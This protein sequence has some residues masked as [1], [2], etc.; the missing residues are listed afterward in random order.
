M[1]RIKHINADSCFL[2]TFLPSSA[3]PSASHTHPGAFTILIDPWLSGP[4]K[5]FSSSFALTLHTVDACVASLRDLP[6]PDLI[7]IS[8]D[9]NDHC[10]KATLTELPGDIESRIV[11]TEKAVRKIRAWKHFRTERMQ[12][13]PRFEP[14]VKESVLRIPI[15]G[16]SPTDTP[17]EVTIA[18]LAPKADLIGLH[19][20]F[21]ITYR[22]PQLSASSP[23][24]EPTLSLLYSP[25]GI[26]LP[27]VTAYASSP[28]S[29][30][31]PGN[32]P[33][34]ALLHCLDSI[35]MPWYLGGSI[36]SGSSSGVAIA[37]ALGVKVWVGAHDEEKVNSGVSLKS[38]R[39]VR[40]ERGQVRTLLGWKGAEV[41][42]KEGEE[43]KASAREG[44]GGGIGEKEVDE[45]AVEREMG[46]DMG[47]EGKVVTV[48]RLMELAPG[49]EVCV[50]GGMD[51]EVT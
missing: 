14:R 18:L 35:T 38:L 12:A 40:S 22:A 50:R 24:P 49:E 19:N 16:S 11:G 30:L 6:V 26:A 21:A 3:S 45:K 41:V 13:C 7:L 48:T 43:E 10:H 2:L 42:L 4:S 25:H 32:L 33:L 27:L 39:I 31:S 46:R 34:T 5:V 44:M 36:C 47:K 9:K 15:P 8:Q 37:K 51:E 23:T 20:A 29:P 1:L 17:G 28:L